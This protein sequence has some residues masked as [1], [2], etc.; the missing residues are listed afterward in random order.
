VKTEL[1][2]ER[3][4]EVLAY[5]PE[6][7]NFKWRVKK[8]TWLSVGDQA[9][10]Q[11]VKIGYLQIRIDGKLYY[12]HRLAFLYM[13]GTMPRY[14]DHI[15]CNKADNRWANLREAT[16]SQNIA[17][18]GMFAHNK[19]G[20]KGVYWD[21]IRGEWGSKIKV[22]QKNIHL[23]FFGDCKAAAHLAY[24]VAAD[25]YFGEFARSA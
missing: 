19:S 17:N 11:N 16:Q 12:G 2:A 22:M 10:N 7:G 8:A 14:V 25:K 1:T 5:D 21:K 15:N 9:G 18:S 23:G 20:L 24:V 6:T 3:L 13:A 4:C